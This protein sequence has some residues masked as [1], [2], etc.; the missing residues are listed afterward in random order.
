MS[1]RAKS[2]CSRS[3]KSRMV[4]MIRYASSSLAL[5]SGN[6]LSV[7]EILPAHVYGGPF[8][9]RFEEAALHC[10]VRHAGGNI[11][12]AKGG[13]AQRHRDVV[14]SGKGDLALAIEGDRAGID[15]ERR[16]LVEIDGLDTFYSDRLDQ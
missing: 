11:N 10:R 13:V 15:G 14:G 6:G 1:P 12:G 7:I 2:T 4:R 3:S 9:H 5:L 8:S 16:R